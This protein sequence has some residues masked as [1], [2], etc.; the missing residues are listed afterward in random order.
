MNGLAPLAPLGGSAAAEDPRR[1]EIREAAEAFEALFLQTLIKKMR[2]AQLE[3][4]LF[5]EGTGASGYESMF[6]QMLGERLAGASQ[7][8]IA[9]A[10]E[11]RWAGIPG[12]REEALAALRQAAESGAKVRQATADE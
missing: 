10:L 12:K 7:L 2:E 9:D 5:G 3:T 6:D 8:G 1:G 11:Q 4:G